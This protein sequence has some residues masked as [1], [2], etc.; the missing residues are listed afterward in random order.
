MIGA[1]LVSYLFAGLALTA[2]FGEDDFGFSW[3][4]LS[5]G[6]VLIATSG[7]CSG[8]CW[9]DF[10]VW[11]VDFWT[12]ERGV[13]LQAVLFWSLLLLTLPDILTPRVQSTLTSGIIWFLYWKDGSKIANADSLKFSFY[14]WLVRMAVS[15]AV[16][17]KHDSEK[18][19]RNMAE[20]IF[21]LFFFFKCV[22]KRVPG[23]QCSK[24]SS[25]K[26]TIFLT[27]PYP[28]W[29][30]G[31]PCRSCHGLLSPLPLYFHKS[32]LALKSLNIIF[33]LTLQKVDFFCFSLDHV[34]DL[35]EYF[36]QRYQI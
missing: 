34:I 28:A 19:N 36:S 22:R 3:K 26:R 13:P 27:K 5:A 10:P 30:S 12:T 17:W 21:K 24:I 23:R 15:Y 11:N 31:G 35:W 20:Y 25:L 2:T 8:F 14:Y 33:F 1:V 18:T 32:G 29:F 16:R 9:T 4:H 6:L 7:E